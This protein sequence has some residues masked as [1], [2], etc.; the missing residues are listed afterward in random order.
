MAEEPRELDNRRRNRYTTIEFIGVTDLEYIRNM[1]LLFSLFDQVNAPVA[2]FND[3]GVSIDDLNDHATKDI[4][5]ETGLVAAP[6][7]K[8]R[9]KRSK[10]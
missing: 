4:W 2:L 3:E 5:E 9:A 7:R 10:V 1:N 6:P 8:P